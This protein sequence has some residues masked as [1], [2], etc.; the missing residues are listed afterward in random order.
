MNDKGRGIVAAVVAAATYGMNPLFTLPLYREG[1]DADSVLFYRYVLGVA[2]LGILMKRR[3]ESFALRG[4]EIPPLVVAGLLVSFSSLFLFLSYRHMDAGIASTILFVYPVMVAVIMAVCFREKVTPVT[5]CSILL[6]LAGI[7]LLYRGGDGGTLS[8]TGVALVLLS[9]LSYAIYI[10]GVNKSMLREMPGCRLTFYA[11]LFGLS[12]YVVRLR[13]CLEL[14]TV[15]SWAAWGNLLALA[16][17]PTVVSLAGTAL[18]VRWIGP[19]PTAILGALE[20]VTAVFFGV[21][22][23][24][25]QLT[26]RLVAGI[27]LVI[28]AVLLILG[29]KQMTAW[30]NAWFFRMASRLRR[31]R[32][33]GGRS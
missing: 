33:S 7:S 10:V 11:L 15:P 5:V 26:L 18:A 27:V 16:F 20:P 30:W 6:A 24:K 21:T 29:G 1:M 8:L 31:R 22:V 9:S 2:M 17:F 28:A 19:T 13:F 32:S 25:E 12:V 14:D 23:F 3:R 4:G